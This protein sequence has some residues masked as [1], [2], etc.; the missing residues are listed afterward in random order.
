MMN[1]ALAGMYEDKSSS[2]K[3][4]R[5]VLQVNGWA[6]YLLH[7]INKRFGG[8]DALHR[9]SKIRVSLEQV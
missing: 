7:S 5:M 8:F 4:I 1:L 9:K 6:T 3:M 2:R